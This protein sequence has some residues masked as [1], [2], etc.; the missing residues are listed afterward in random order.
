M[1]V[2]RAAR[3]GNWPGSNRNPPDPCRS[4]EKC[5]HPIY[6]GKSFKPTKQL[7][8]AVSDR[9]Y[10]AH[11]LCKRAAFWGKNPKTGYRADAGSTWM[12]GPMVELTATRLT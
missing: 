2:N 8:P 11:M 10:A 3:M 6:A 7:A 1:P 9:T 5:S 4:K 12:P